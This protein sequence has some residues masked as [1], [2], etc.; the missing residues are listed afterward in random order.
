MDDS[1]FVFS[2]FLLHFH[3]P[4]FFDAG[5]EGGG[6]KAEKF[7]CPAGAVDF[8]ARLVQGSFNIRLFAQAH[9]R[10]GQDCA[11]AVSVFLDG[12]LSEAPLAWGTGMSN[13]INPHR[14]EITACSMMFC[15]S[16]FVGPRIIF[17]FQCLA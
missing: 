10:L 11:G 8:P 6:F 9:V 12:G 3:N 16:P 2:F 13:C 14:D 7:G 1:A 5:E 17:Q 4:H 15:I